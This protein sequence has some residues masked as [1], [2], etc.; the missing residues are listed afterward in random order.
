MP[1][2]TLIGACTD[3]SHIVEDLWC[4][5]QSVPESVRTTV[6]NHEHV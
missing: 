2:W 4:N 3:G 6:R 1:V 5:L